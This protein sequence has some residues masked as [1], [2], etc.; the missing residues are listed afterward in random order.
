MRIPALLT[1]AL[2]LGASP[3]SAWT[4]YAYLDQNV[5]IQFPAK[6]ADDKGDL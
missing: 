1:L 5:A 3:A 2:V 4:E 6:P